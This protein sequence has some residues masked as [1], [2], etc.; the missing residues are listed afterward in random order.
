RFGPRERELAEALAAAIAPSIRN[1]RRFEDVKVE[2]ARSRRA[3]AREKAGEPL[4]LLGRSRALLEL[5]ELID[6][7]AP[8][9]HTVLV[10]GE[11]GS[12]KEL[13]ARAIHARSDRAS[14]PFVA[15]N[16]SAL[17]EGVLEA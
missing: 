12:G 1:A 15:E 6:R 9:P 11:S 16:V 13:V 14:G 7:I 17:A 8:S 3:R 10:Q 5:E 2:L 4:R